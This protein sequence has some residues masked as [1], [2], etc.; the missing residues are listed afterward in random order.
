MDRHFSPQ[1]QEMWDRGP[2]LFCENVE[3][4]FFGQRKIFIFSLKKF[5]FI[6]LR[7]NLCDSSTQGK[8]LEVEFRS[9][10]HYIKHTCNIQILIKQGR[11]YV[12]WCFH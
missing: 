10:R 8:R 5:I 9:R 12:P 7:F 1:V 11:L 2:N 6:H 4:L 3:D